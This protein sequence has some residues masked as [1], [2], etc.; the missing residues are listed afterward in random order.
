[1][2]PSLEEVNPIVTDEIDDA[3]FLRQPPRP[4]AGVEILE[5]LRLADAGERISKNSLDEIEHFE[6]DL[7]I[8]LFPCFRSS[9]NSAWKTASRDA[10]GLR[11][12]E[13]DL[14]P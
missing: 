11:M 9:R 6:S 1:M 3:V 14:T 2:I 7:A 10:A 5:R 8:R 13:A 4:R 12:V